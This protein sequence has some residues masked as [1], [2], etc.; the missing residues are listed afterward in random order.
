MVGSGASHPVLQSPPLV[1]QSTLEISPP[2]KVSFSSS[3]TSTTSTTPRPY[4]LRG[5][6]KYSSTPVLEASPSSIL[7]SATKDLVVSN[8]EW[9]LEG[10]AETEDSSQLEQDSGFE[11]LTSEDSSLPVSPTPR[12]PGP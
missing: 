2:T 9:R 8:L 4:F 10:L 12:S 6:A 7:S 3:T 5:Q 1:K 11:T